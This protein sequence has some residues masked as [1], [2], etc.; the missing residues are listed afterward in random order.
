MY[1]SYYFE[2]GNIYHK[3]E[4]DKKKNK[5]TFKNILNKYYTIIKNKCMST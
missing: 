3:I 2:N 5:N 1:Q 4:D